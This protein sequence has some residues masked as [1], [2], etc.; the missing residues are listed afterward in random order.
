MKEGDFLNGF[1]ELMV[2]ACNASEGQLSLTAVEMMDMLITEETKDIM[3]QSE[4][5]GKEIADIILQSVREIEDGSLQT[6]DNLVKRRVFRRMGVFC[7]RN[8]R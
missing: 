7:Y 5:G 2:D 8:R 4:I 6:V 3:L 1:N